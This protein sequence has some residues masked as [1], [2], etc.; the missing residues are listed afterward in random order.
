MGRKTREIVEKNG[1][2]Y[3][4]YAVKRGRLSQMFTSI[5]F[6]LLMAIQCLWIGR[7]YRKK[8]FIAEAGTIDL[9]GTEVMDWV[10]KQMDSSL[11]DA[12][13]IMV[14]A[15]TLVLMVFVICVYKMIKG[16]DLYKNKWVR[17]IPIIVF[18]VFVVCAVAY[19]KNVLFV[20]LTSGY[21]LYFIEFFK[22]LLP[23]ELREYYAV[24]IDFFEFFGQRMIKKL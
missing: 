24:I 1:I 19:F 22:L 14:I 12:W 11:L 5:G 23:L 18:I 21:F 7:I 2:Y 8:K 16:Y 13:T 3:G 4:S 15:I 9:G 20:V 6:I 17:W 10:E